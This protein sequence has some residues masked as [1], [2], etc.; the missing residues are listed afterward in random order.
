MAKEFQELCCD[1]NLEAVMHAAFKRGVYVNGKDQNGRTG[2][3]L[4]LMENQKKVASFL[5]GQDS[6][7]I[8]VVSDWGE[9]ALHWV[10]WRD[11][12][13]IA[14]ICYLHHLKLHKF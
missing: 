1:G 4:A 3:M 2:L 7:D 14:H 8:N 10:A 11:N 13:S 6:V 5:L 12:R 9:T